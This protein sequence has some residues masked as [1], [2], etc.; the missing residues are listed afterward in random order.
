MM[1]WLARHRALARRFGR[2]GAYAAWTALGGLA[3][4][5]LALSVFVVFVL[6]RQKAV[7]ARRKARPAAHA[8]WTLALGVTTVLELWVAAGFVAL[9]WSAQLW[10]L[11]FVIA[12]AFM[13][14][15]LGAPVIRHVLVPLG[16]ARTAYTVGLYSWTGPDAQAYALCAAAWASRDGEAMAWVETMRGLRKP[17]GDGEIAATGLV[18]ARRGDADT[19]RALLRSLAMMVERHP[20]VR[21]LAGE[22][23]ACDAAERGAWRELADDALAARWPA[24]PLR[25]VLEGVTLRFTAHADAPSI[26][27]LW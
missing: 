15:P 19:A 7:D 6:V 13:V 17:L 10:W 14:P 26:A 3:N 1:R 5:L 24:T 23:L 2:P 20:A 4:T 25:H 9:A 27:G 21:E 22:W 11:A 18:A 12:A 8:W 16:W